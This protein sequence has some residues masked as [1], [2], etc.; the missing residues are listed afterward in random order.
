MEK[1]AVYAYKN[2]VT[3]K[4]A[5]ESQ[6]AECR[7]F[8]ESSGLEVVEVYAD[9]HTRSGRR[10]LLRE[11]KKRNFSAVIVSSADRIDRNRERFFRIVT[12]LQKN[13]VRV[14]FANGG[15]TVEYFSFLK[16]C[17]DLSTGRS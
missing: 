16:Y 15:N 11:S 8:A 13:G 5:V 2:C 7:K 9:I 14:Y 10:K 4:Q 12:A 6:I 3:G 1:A 17:A